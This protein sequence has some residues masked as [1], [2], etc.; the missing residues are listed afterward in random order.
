MIFPK[1][2]YFPPFLHIFT[3]W[4]QAMSF[5]SVLSGLDELGSL[6]GAIIWGIERVIGRLFQFSPDFHEK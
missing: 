5:I 6:F 2:A 3:N 1:N 4:P